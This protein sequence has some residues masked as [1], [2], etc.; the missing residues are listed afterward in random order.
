M[1][2][3]P[4]LAQSPQ[5]LALVIGISGYDDQLG[6]LPSALKD[7]ES[8]E[9]ALKT[10]GFQ[11]TILE[12]A[13]H[14]E[15]VESLSAFSARVKRGDI[16]LVYYAGHGVQSSGV[17]YILPVDFHTSSDLEKQSLRLD[18]IVHQV[19]LRSPKLSIFVFD[20]CRTKPFG[21]VRTP[22]LA[23]IQASNYGPGDNVGYFSHI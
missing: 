18:T 12:D 9:G 16:V 20:A 21:P 7:T 14:S 15:L 19:G 8:V 6:R 1:L 22:G 23:Q 3:N 5:R 4:I 2:I 17:N 13:T 11:V 10:V